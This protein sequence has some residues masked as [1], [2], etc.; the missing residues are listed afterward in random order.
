MIHLQT[1]CHE[2]TGIDGVD[3]WTAWQFDS[4]V[5]H[6]GM[7]VESKC[8]TLDD[9]G[10]FPYSLDDVL[11]EKPLKAYKSKEAKP[12]H[13]GKKGQKINKA[14]GLPIERY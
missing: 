5:L 13:K 12:L 9:E 3:E 14:I 8:N 7:W 10:K 2:A 11:N 1:L 6:F 4:A